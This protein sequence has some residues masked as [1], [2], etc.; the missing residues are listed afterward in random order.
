[1]KKIV[2]FCL[3][4][5]MSFWFISQETFAYFVFVDSHAGHAMIPRSDYEDT[6]STN[7]ENDDLFGTSYL[8]SQHTYGTKN[9][10]NYK[11]W[12]GISTMRSVPQYEILVFRYPI[13]LD[14][15]LADVDFSVND[16]S[17]TD[18]NVTQVIP[19]EVISEDY[20]FSSS[21]SQTERFYLEA[22]FDYIT[23]TQVGATIP[24]YGVEFGL[25][26]STTLQNHIEG[27]YES[28]LVQ[29]L[30]YSRSGTITIDNTPSSPYY[31]N[32]AIIYANYGT[33]AIYYLQVVVVCEPYYY[34]QSTYTTGTW[35]NKRTYYVYDDTYAD[36]NTLH[37]S[38]NYH[39]SYNRGT[40]P[41]IYTWNQ[42]NFSYE[43]VPQMR[44]S[45]RVYIR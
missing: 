18:F 3:M 44:E 41:F 35:F 4:L 30:S 42:S 12:L 2:I 9:I 7:F 33:R 34:L 10:I 5:L 38:Y 45:N 19:N 23:Q 26:T 20:T 32:G 6:A 1:M 25:S 15:F 24:Y 11:N 16:F 43:L 27:Q 8:V 13:M 14:T 40:Q 37:A 36:Y 29:T 21:E 17:F 22:S 28:T 39:S 31:Q